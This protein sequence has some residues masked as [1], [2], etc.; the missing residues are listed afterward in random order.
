M[1]FPM[2]G[3]DKTKFGG[4]SW[5]EGDIVE[6]IDCHC[7]AIV[8]LGHIFGTIQDI[9]PRVPLFMEDENNEPVTVKFC[10]LYR[11]VWHRK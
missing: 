4:R 10:E 7:R 5:K 2:R 1:G 3:K 11:M 9:F 6:K 8:G